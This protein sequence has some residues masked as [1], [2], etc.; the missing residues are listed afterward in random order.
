MVHDIEKLSN[1]GIGIKK[2]LLFAMIIGSVKVEVLLAL[3]ET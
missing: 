2:I 1:V 3:H